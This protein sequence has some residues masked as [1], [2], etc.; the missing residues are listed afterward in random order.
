VI[1]LIDPGMDGATAERRR[2]EEQRRKMVAWQIERREIHDERVLRAMR[3]V[4]RHEFVPSELRESA[5]DDCALPIGF[6]QTISQP[7]IVAFTVAH[8]A[9]RPEDRVL[10]V[11]SGSGYQAAVLSKL[12]AQVFAIEIVDA[13][14]LRSVYDLRRL[15]FD[16]VL[17]RNGDGYEGWPESAPFDA[18]AV[19]AALDHIPQ[20]LVSQLRVG[21]R[22][23]MP[24]G[25]AIGQQLIL[26]EKENDGTHMR[27]LCP[28]RFVPFIRKPMG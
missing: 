18:I 19:A 1:S 14:V 23:V 12:V 4:P 27:T 6:G 11:G 25:N 8:L 9:L 3:E 10:E 7:Y 16:N 24:I 21:G 22:M 15:H 20:P 26:V 5:H 2:A 17:V 13:L 28:V